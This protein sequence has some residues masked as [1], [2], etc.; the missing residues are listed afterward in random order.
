MN[1]GASGSFLSYFGLG[2]AVLAALG[3]TAWMWSIS[4]FTRDGAIANPGEYF[5]AVNYAVIAAKGYDGLYLHAFF[6]LFPLVM[7]LLS[8]PWLAAAFNAL[9]F[10]LSA[11]ALAREWKPSYPHFLMFFLLPSSVFFLL[12]YS[13]ALFFAGGS[14]FLL[15][16]RR[17]AVWLGVLGLL[18]A[19]LSR[20]AASVFLPALILLF[21]LNPER[22][23]LKSLLIHGA[24]VLISFFGAWLIQDAWNG[25]WA[26]FFEAQKGWGNELR[27]PSFP[28]KTW[29]SDRMILWLDLLALVI[30]V[31]AGLHILFLGR[32]R[33]RREL[34][35][36]DSATLFSLLYLAGISSTILLFRGGEIFSLNRF[37]FAVPFTAWLMYSG[38]SGTLSKR[39]I[40]AVLA[41]LFLFFL[42]NGAYVHIRVA[43][44][45]LIFLAFTG[46]WLYGLQ[47]RPTVITYAALMAMLLSQCYFLFKVANNEWIAYLLLESNKIVF[48][49]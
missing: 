29:G 2:I 7:K 39:W 33:L 44:G 30:G 26:R 28:L 9:I 40:P 46:I 5:D 18:V 16:L 8:S 41:T 47:G 19:G 15:S 32:R 38:F 17:N 43:L 22:Y 13:E 45:A 14:L 20:P 1:T 12:P 49:S 23:K 4:G 25:E 36:S 42:V 3:C 34:V 27:I 48:S 10:A 37:V 35:S 24:T 31:F 11:A 21:W 6:P